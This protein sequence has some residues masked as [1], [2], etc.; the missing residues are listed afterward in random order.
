MIRIVPS[1][2]RHGLTGIRSRL[3]DIQRASIVGVLVVVAP[4]GHVPLDGAGVPPVAAADSI[5]LLGQIDLAP[6]GTLNS[7]I[8]GWVDPLTSKEYAIVGEWNGF[9]VY[10]VDV[11]DPTSPNIISTIT[12]SFGFGFDVKTWD[13]YLYTVDGNGSGQ[14]GKI[15]D[16]ANPALPV[17]V[18]TFLSAHNIFIDDNGIMYN[19]V[20]GLTIFDLKP[21]PTNPDSLWS[22]GSSGHDATAIGNR[23]YDFHGSAG[24]FIYDITNPAS[25]VLLGSITDPNIDYHHSGWPSADG[26]YLYI[27]DELANDPVPDITVWD[28]SNPATPFKVDEFGD[29]NATIHNT[30]RVGNF[31]FASYYTAGFK[32]FD[33]SNPLAMQLVDE[34]DTSALSG[35][36]FDGAWGCYPFAPSGNIYVSDM[37]NG[38][39]I[40]SFSGTTPTAIPKRA[41]V[42]FALNQNFPNPFNPTTTITYTLESA[43]NVVLTVYDAAGRR[44]RTLLNGVQGAGAQTATWNGRDNRGHRVASGVYFYRLEAGGASDTRRMVFLK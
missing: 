16:I 27:N 17:Q 12:S 8:W 5:T 20:S 25:P 32:I 6:G 39:Y 34:F 37:Q 21:D 30:F 29:P 41:P 44:I 7:D 14:D 28:I 43:G 35:E 9:N 22:G 11:S 15:F 40:F 23:L 3:T 13:H 24:T 38:L 31:L 26:N 33:I 2:I 4:L 1:R 18:G 10:I 36:G 42:G 19:E